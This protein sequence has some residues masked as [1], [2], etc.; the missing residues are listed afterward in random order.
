MKTFKIPNY[1]IIHIKNI[2]FD[3]NG[4]IQYN[5]KIL[6]EVIREIKNLKN[7]YQVFLI[8]ADTR[9]NLNEIADL[10]KVKSIKISKNESSEADAKNNELMKLG[11]DVTIAIG[12]GNNDYLM[13]RNAVIGISIL[14]NEGATSKTIMDSDIV[15]TNIIDAIHFLMDEKK[16][17]A[18]LRN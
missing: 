1:G 3:I 5:G 8:S 11:K 7:F 10:L 15:F 16:I 4:T 9:G 18:T 12:N 6:K 13:L 17:I 2:L 14:G